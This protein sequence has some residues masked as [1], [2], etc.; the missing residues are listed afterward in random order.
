MQICWMGVPKTIHIVLIASRHRIEAITE[1]ITFCNYYTLIMDGIFVYI[2]PKTI[3]AVIVITILASWLVIRTQKAAKSEPPYLAEAVPYISNTYEFLTDMATFIKRA[4]ETFEKTQSQ[5]VK[6]Y[7]GLRSVYMLAGQANVQQLFQSPDDVLGVNFV[8]VELMRK[9]Q[10]WTDQEISKFVGD[11]T[12]RL[13]TPAKGSIASPGGKRYWHEHNNLYLSHLSRKS[14]DALASRYVSL[15]TELLANQGRP[16]DAEWETM[17]LLEFLGTAICE[18]AIVTMFGSRILEAN[19]D[20]VQAYFDFDRIALNLM[21]GLPRWLRP[22]PYRTRERLHKMV[23]M[24]FTSAWANFDWEGPESESEWEPQFGSRLTRETTRWML[25]SG[26]SLHAAAGHVVA[27]MFGSNGNT[28]PLI[29]WAMVEL[30]QDPELL[31]RVREE[32]A[33]VTTTDPSNGGIKIDAGAL[34]VLPLLQS[35][36]TEL[37]RLH[38]SFSAVREV[39]KPVVVDGYQIPKG[40]L[41][42]ASTDMA[43][44]QEDVW[45][46]EGHPAN[47]F[48]AERHLSYADSASQQPRFSMKG[49]A[50]AFFPFSGGFLICPGRHF[51][52]Q[53]VL[54]TIAVLVMSFDLELVNWVNPDGSVRDKPPRDDAAYTGFVVR[55]PDCDIKIRWKRR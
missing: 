42:H 20:F 10:D 34:I 16:S 14:S 17:H 21:Y 3:L 52:K 6:F 13:K 53:E 31:R 39:L 12:G 45:G 25:E 49:R 48:W 55:P 46:T 36:F 23:D 40:S 37:L 11:R 26:F 5:V 50:S 24:H 4:T 28:I 54:L 19:P 8:Q 32:V 38:V 43:H 44:L 2:Y 22:G 41:L 18:G 30:V 15:L 7:L 1:S 33:T 29:K 51:A 9:H 35:I 47:T 27:I